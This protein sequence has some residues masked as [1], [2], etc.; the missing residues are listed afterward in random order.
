M[1]RNEVL[2]ARWLATKRF[3][4]VYSQ[5]VAFFTNQRWGRKKGSIFSRQVHACSATIN[6]QLIFLGLWN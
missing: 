4:Y 6:M 5:Q 3:M 2:H 1:A